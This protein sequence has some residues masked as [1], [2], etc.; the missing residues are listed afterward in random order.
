MHSHVV[1]T[2][3]ISLG[4]NGSSSSKFKLIIRQVKNLTMHIRLAIKTVSAI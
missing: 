2:T 1:V 3:S 4:A